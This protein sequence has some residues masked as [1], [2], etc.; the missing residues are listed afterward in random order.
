MLVPNSKFTN[1]NKYGWLHILVN[2]C[3]IIQTTAVVQDSKCNNFAFLQNTVVIPCTI[4]LQTLL[5]SCVL[6]LWLVLLLKHDLKFLC[7]MLHSHK[8]HTAASDDVC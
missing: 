6:P 7:F 3:C 8:I 4:I 1:T 2:Q 5:Y